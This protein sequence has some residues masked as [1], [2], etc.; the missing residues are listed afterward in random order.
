MKIHHKDTKNTKRARSL[1]AF[2]VFFVSLWCVR[3]EEP[4]ADTFV[5]Q[6]AAGTTHTGRL[7]Q[8]DEKW[9][10][11]LGNE[12]FPGTEVVGLRRTQQPLPPYPRDEQLLFAN[13]DRLAARVLELNGER[14]QCR[15][16]PEWGDEQSVTVPLSAVSVIWLH[17][18]NDSDNPHLLRRQ[19]ATTQRPRDTLLLRNGDILEGIFTSLDETTVQL[20]V[21][22]K[23]VKHARGK[24]AAIALSTELAT[25]L[26][27]SGP[28]GRFVL[29]NGSR[30]S[31]AQATG[32]DGKNLSGTTLFDTP[33]RVPLHQ[34]LALAVFQGAAVHLSDLKPANFTS[35]S[36][37]TPKEN[38]PLV[39]DGSVAG[40]D[41]RLAGSTYDKGLGMHSASRVTYSLG[42][43]YRRFEAL[44]GL[45]DQTGRLGSVR[46]Q[47]LADGKPVDV[48]WDKELTHQN[49]PVPVRANIAGARALTLVV[50]FGEGG[51]VQDHVDWVDAR[52][53]K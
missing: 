45:D 12:H 21:D 40:R 22:K 14:L 39:T 52:L 7:Q 25:P 11:R 9:S 20:E 41:L 51:D 37:L 24:V 1:G 26:R 5:L 35:S 47:V 46:I 50:D 53:I 6:T 15:L 36:Y 17:P 3:G 27:P 10:V 28:Y 18:P 49:G 29:A 44:V 23:P 2:F 43:A 4:A 16:P 19:L 13:G 31:L 30:L 34:V 48:G 38:W 42:G 32:F 8:L 33:I